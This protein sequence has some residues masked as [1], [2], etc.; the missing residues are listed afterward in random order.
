MT[1]NAACLSA[2]QMAVINN[3]YDLAE[4]LLKYGADANHV[5]CNEYKPVIANAI[6]TG[7]PAI[8][9]LLLNYNAGVNTE[10][11]EDLSIKVIDYARQKGNKMIIEM[12]DEKLQQSM[13]KKQEVIEE[14]NA[15]SLIKNNVKQDNKTVNINVNDNISKGSKPDNMLV[16]ENAAPKVNKNDNNSSNEIDNIMNNIVN[17][18]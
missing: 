2:L 9:R 4:V 17:G 13:P 5:D 7:N 1:A 12:I 15:S 3:N 16:K 18:L 14:D 6:D 11:G 8:V 10:V